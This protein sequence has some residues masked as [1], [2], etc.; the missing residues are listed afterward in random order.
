MF[1][2]DSILTNIY[3]AGKFVIDLVH[4]IFC[5]YTCYYSSKVMLCLIDLLTAI[6][7]V[8]LQT[9]TNG[10]IIIQNLAKEIQISFTCD[11]KLQ[12][13]I[14]NREL[15]ISQVSRLREIFLH[16]DLTS[17]IMTIS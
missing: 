14:E 8:F 11:L 15:A 6:I 17:N 9:I 5:I 13:Y 16:T 10:P 1:D 3:K 4:T 7:Q 2:L 12:I